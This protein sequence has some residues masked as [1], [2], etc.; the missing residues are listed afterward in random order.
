MSDMCNASEESVNFYDVLLANKL[1]SYASIFIDQNMTDMEKIAALSDSDLL[2]MGIA[3]YEVRQRIIEAFAPYE[4]VNF[5]DILLKTGLESYAPCFLNSNITDAR[6]IALL[7]HTDLGALGIV[8]SD[9]Q[10]GIIRAFNQYKPKSV[11]YGGE[12]KTSATNYT[13]SNRSSYGE[14]A[15][16]THTKAHSNTLLLILGGI[17]V[18]FGMFY[19]LKMTLADY[20]GQYAKKHLVYAGSYGWT[21]LITYH[22][23]YQLAD[24][25]GYAITNIP[26]TTIL[27]GDA[28]FI[29]RQSSGQDITDSEEAFRQYLG[30]SFLGGIFGSSLFGSKIGNYGY[31]YAVQYSQVADN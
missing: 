3:S 12:Y 19:L 2:N 16:S 27:S 1:E 31:Y 11:T 10:S 20:N 4:N 8:D 24:V 6:K 30:S 13:D 26:F 5:Y 18:I 23:G 21:L 9:V 15:N 25:Q 29:F 14:N 22:S 28:A 17:I 7:N